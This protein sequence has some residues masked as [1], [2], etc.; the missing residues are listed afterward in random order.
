MNE[1]ELK[2]L[3]QDLAAELDWWQQSEGFLWDIDLK[4]RVKDLGIEIDDRG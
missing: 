3:I 2:P 1:E 4:K